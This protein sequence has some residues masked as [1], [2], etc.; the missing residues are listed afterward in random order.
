MRVPDDDTGVVGGGGEQGSVGRELTGHHVVMVTLQLPDQGIF[1]HIPKE[2][3]QKEEV[4]VR[5]HGI[6]LC[7]D[8]HLKATSIK[9]KN[10]QSILQV[11]K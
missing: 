11:I 10:R 6:T 5:A 2:H 3:L 7:M 9:C 8:K 4:H 1:I